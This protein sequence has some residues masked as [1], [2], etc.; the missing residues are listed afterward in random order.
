MEQQCL[1][2][3]RRMT[4]AALDDMKLARSALLR[5]LAEERFDLPRYIKSHTIAINLKYLDNIATASAMTSFS[6]PLH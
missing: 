5:H 4:S 2:D 1:H 3:E 6:N